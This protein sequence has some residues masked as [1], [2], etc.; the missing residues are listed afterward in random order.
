VGPSSEEAAARAA[1]AGADVERARAAARESARAAKASEVGAPT[2]PLLD[3]AS[4]VFVTETL[5][6]PN[7]SHKPC[8]PQAEKWTSVRPWAEEGRVAEEGAA[9]AAVRSAKVRWC[10]LTLG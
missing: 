5:Q 6:P 8:S 4:A 3:S 7:V 1:A 2:R 9:A 10:R